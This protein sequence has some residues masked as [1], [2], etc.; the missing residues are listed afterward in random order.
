VKNVLRIALPVL[1]LLAVNVT[2]AEQGNR[3]YQIG[4]VHSVYEVVTETSDSTYAL[5]TLTGK[6]IKA[7][8]V[9]SPYTSIG[10][11]LY[12]VNKC[13]KSEIDCKFS[14]KVFGQTIEFLTGYNMRNDGVFIYT[15]A[16]YYWEANKS[17]S[18]GSPVI[19][20][21]IG[22][23]YQGIAVEAT[24]E[25]R[26]DYSDFSSFDILSPGTTSDAVPAQFA[27]SYIF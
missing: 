19:P 18:I 24:V 27:L 7:N 12:I 21:G 1:L 10:G 2:Y 16:R 3:K 6:G 22:F 23:R 11:S 20:L 15:G 14:S 13:V 4:L 8:Y 17:S 25:L 26:D 9:Y 5:S